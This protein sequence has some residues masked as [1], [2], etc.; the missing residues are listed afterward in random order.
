MRTL[1]IHKYADVSLGNLVLSSDDSIWN[2][3]KYI[4]D[5][6]SSY[7][8]IF[9]KIYNL[10]RLLLRFILRLKKFE[11]KNAVKFLQQY[12]RFRISN[13]RFLICKKRLLLEFYEFDSILKMIKKE[14]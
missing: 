12:W 10:R 13:P 2:I 5:G 11:K 8:Y 1:A 14:L 7:K 6:S 4:P 9:A 3:K